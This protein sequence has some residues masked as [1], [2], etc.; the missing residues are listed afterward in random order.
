M[1]IMANLKYRLDKDHPVSFQGKLHYPI[2]AIRDFHDVKMGDRGG[3][4]EGPHTLSHDGDCWIYEGAYVNSG[5]VVTEGAAVKDRA[6]VSHGAMIFGCAVISEDA[7]VGGGKIGG[8]AE[9]KGNAVIL[10][11][12]T[13]ID[14]AVVTD[15]AII[16]GTG[17]ISGKAVI[18]N[19]AVLIGNCNIT[20]SSVVTGQVRDADLSWEASCASMNDYFTTTNVGP[21]HE[22]FIAFK[23]GNGKGVMIVHAMWTMEID[24]FEKDI[25]AFYKSQ[26][27]RGDN[28]IAEYETL[29]AYTRQK[30]IQGQ[31]YADKSS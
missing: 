20:G 24:E 25:R 4:V 14:Q 30:L 1:G 2:I 15:D 8:Y 17:Y 13:I 10:G 31:D 6:V 22:K 29:L 28:I 3:C 16:K 19:E 23:Q 18:K 26:G 5:A 9:V 12:P 7:V 27:T 21:M 11:R